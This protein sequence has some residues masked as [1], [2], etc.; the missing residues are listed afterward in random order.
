MHEIRSKGTP[1]VIAASQQRASL[2]L[3]EVLQHTNSKLQ[4]PNPLLETL[5]PSVSQ[6]R[7]SLFLCEGEAS[8]TDSTPP[9]S[10]P[11]SLSLSKVVEER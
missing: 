5:N 4:T 9:I 1:N 2:F 11:P 8:H 6:Q 10:P 7:A 3:R